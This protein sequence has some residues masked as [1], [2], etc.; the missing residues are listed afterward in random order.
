MQTRLTRYNDA[1]SAQYHP[2]CQGEIT[3]EKTASTSNVPY[4]VA[5]KPSYA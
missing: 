4:L 5:D 1:A 2:A 3:P